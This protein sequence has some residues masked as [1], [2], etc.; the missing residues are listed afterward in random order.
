[1]TRQLRT[2][3]IELSDNWDRRGLPGWSYHSP[4]LFELEKAQVLLTHWQIAGHV[5]EIPNPGD[6]LSFDMLGERA[7]GLRCYWVAARS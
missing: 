1:M 6:W 7:F 3:R 5:G 4:A 2:T